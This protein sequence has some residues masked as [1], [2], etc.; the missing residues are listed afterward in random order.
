MTRIT[1]V[2]D[3]SVNHGKYMET[4][5]RDSNHEHTKYVGEQMHKYLVGNKDYIDANI[6]INVDVLHGKVTLVVFGELKDFSGMAE[7][8]NVLN[9]PIEY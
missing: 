2:F 6:V 4:M 8:L 9:T 7:A 5:R 1:T 3:T